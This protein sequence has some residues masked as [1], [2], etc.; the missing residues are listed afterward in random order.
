MRLLVVPK[1]MNQ[2]GGFTLTEVIVV[3]V[4]S[5]ILNAIL[6]PS[7]IGS[8]Q[9]NKVKE[10]FINLRKA[11][12]QAQTNANRLSNDCTVNISATTISGSP[13]GCILE[14]ITI[15]SSVVSVTKTNFTDTPTSITFSFTGTTSD[16]STSTLWLARKDS[17]N[18]PIQTSAK[19]IV[20]S[21]TGMIKTG[22]YATGS[23][24]PVCNNIE[25]KLYDQY[26]P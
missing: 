6:A 8:L 17:S 2:E 18:T 9:Q 24:P 19:C 12:I 16:A 4:I 23:S 26:N 5:G 21:P 1:K 20:I 25:N 22:I 7:L 14:T 13:T 15:D 11:L 3:I 10:T